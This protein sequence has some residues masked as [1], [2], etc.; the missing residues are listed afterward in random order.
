MIGGNFLAL[1][2]AF[3][4]VVFSFTLKNWEMNGND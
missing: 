2:A 3:N 1:G 4:D